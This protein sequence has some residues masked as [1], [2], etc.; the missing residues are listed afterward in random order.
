[1]NAGHIVVSE[2]FDNPDVVVPVVTSTVSVSAIVAVV[3]ISLIFRYR[4]QRLRQELYA[5]FLQKGEPIP[6]EL[7]PGRAQRGKANADLRRGMV[8]LLGGIGLSLALC[9]AHESSNAG[10]GIIP[11]LIGVAYLVVWKVESRANAES[12]F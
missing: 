10:V 5:S 2:G 8:L 3:A 4:T 6:A 7:L 12:A 11:A 1:M 9:L